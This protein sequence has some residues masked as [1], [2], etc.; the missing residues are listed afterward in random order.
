MAPHQKTDIALPEPDFPDLDGAAVRE[1][2]RE[3]FASVSAMDRNVARVLAELDARG[4]RDNTV[5]VF[6]SDNGYN[7]GHHGIIHKGNGGWI[8]N[9]MRDIPGHDPRRIRPNMWDNSLRV[10]T[11]IR[12]PATLRPGRV[13][14]TIRNLD[15][16]PT[17]LAM[18]GVEPPEGAILHGR[19]FLPLLLGNRIAWDDDLYGE[20][21]QHHYT[22]ADLRMYRTTEWKLVRDFRN[23]GRDELYHLTTDPL[24][25]TNRIAD[26]AARDV[27]EDLDRRLREKMSALTGC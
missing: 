10:P 19:N 20:Y 27:R 11:A 2:T 15:W 5:V 3:Y 7:I 8:T 18:A 12:W 22:E 4:L 13:D 16:F 9:A 1:K 25:Q 24:E 26:D 21:S 14:R 6:T 17:L 23:A